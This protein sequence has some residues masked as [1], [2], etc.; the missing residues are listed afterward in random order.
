MATSKTN[1][2]SAKQAQAQESARRA[3]L[4]DLIQKKPLRRT[5]YIQSGDE[6]LSVVFQSVGRRKYA[7]LVEQFTYKEKAPKV[8]D[9][10]NEVKDRKT[11]ETV[12]EE[13]DQ[14]NTEEFL[15]A[16]I[17]ASAVEPEI[18]HEDAIHFYDNWN[19]TEFDQ[20]AMAAWSVNTQNKVETQG[21]A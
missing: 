1:S 10:G 21:N 15:P 17:A 4:D 13:Q 11:G 5:A 14:L 7:D 9:N 6:T 12:Y 2:K 20:L 19:S 18:S 16:L 3:S 8:D